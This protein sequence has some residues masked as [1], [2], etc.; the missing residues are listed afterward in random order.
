MIPFL[1]NREADRF[2]GWQEKSG[3]GLPVQGATSLQGPRGG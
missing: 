1:L 3:E 2:N